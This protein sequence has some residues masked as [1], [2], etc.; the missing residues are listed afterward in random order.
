MLLR[1]SP[2]FLVL[3]A[4]VAVAS[5]CSDDE[6]A[7]VTTPGEDAIVLWPAPANP[8]ALAVAAGLDPEPSE[9]LVHHRHTHLDVFLDGTQVVVPENLGIDVPVAVQGFPCSQPCISPLHTHDTSGIVHT[10][11]PT[12]EEL[13]LGQ[14]FTEWAVKLTSDCVGEYCAPAKAVAFY[15]DGDQVSGDPNAIKLEENAEI[16][17]VI[18]TPPA[19]IPSESGLG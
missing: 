4:V 9:Q 10:E 12:P 3:V 19:E 16:A 18:G 1:R 2:L 8:M 15:V 11:S 7:T 14:F 17:I 6:K 5:S 13:T